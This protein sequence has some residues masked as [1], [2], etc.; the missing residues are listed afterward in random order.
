VRRRR[1]VR[2]RLHLEAGAEVG[3][4]V[5]GAIHLGARVILRVIILPVR[6][7]HIPVDHLL[8]I[9]RIHRTAPIQ[10]HHTV[11]R[12]RAQ[13]SSSLHCTFKS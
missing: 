1:A 5:I 13:I 10:G 3:A 2:T 7:V 6:T 4:Q 11:H 12:V 8:R 9:A